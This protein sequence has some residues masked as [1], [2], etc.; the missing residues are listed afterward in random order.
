MKKTKHSLNTWAFLGIYLAIL[1]VFAGVYTLSRRLDQ[2]SQVPIVGTYTPGTYTASDY[3]FGGQVSVSLT[4]GPNGG[5]DDVTL[6]A[7]SETDTIGGAAL[8]ALRNQILSAQSDEIDGVSGATLTSTG[9]RNAV[10]QALAAASGQQVSVAN[11]P[12]EGA[13]FV[14]GT[15]EK[16]AR[17]FG[18]DCTVTLTVSDNEITDVIIDGSSETEN[19]GSFAVTLLQKSIL[20]NQTTKVDAISGATVTSNAILNAA[21]QALNAA[22]AD[23]SKLP[24]AETPEI[25]TA[26]KAQQTVET[27]VVVV[28]A[29]GAGMTAAINAA[30]AGKNV[31]IVEKMP[32]AGGN[33]TKATGGMN[34]AGTKYQA[35]IEFTNAKG[36][37]N[38][39]ATA[40]E[41]WAGNEA[42][43]ALAETVQKQWDAY[44]ADPQGYFDTPELMALDTMIG[45]KGINDSALVETLCSNSAD[46]IDWLDEHGITLHSVSSF[47]GASVKR[48]HRPVNAEGKTVSVGSYMIPLLQENC[49]KAGVQTLLNTTATELLTDANGAVVGV[50]ATGSTGE[51]IT[52]NAKAV[53]LTTG[54]FGANL[55]MVTEYKPELKGFMTTNAAGAQGQGIE[56][57]TAVGA[58]TV[59]MDQIQIHPTVEANTAALIT[60]GLRGDGAVLINAEG[61]RFIDE[62]GTRDVVSAAEI[63]QTGSYSWL[64]VDQA[65][66]DASSVIQGYIKKGYTVTG[67]TY[68]ELA[69]AMGVDEAAF[70][71]T[72]KTWNGYV[73]AKNDPD[74]GR[75]SFA[76]ALDTAPYYAIKVTAGVHHTMGGL[77]IN[78]NTEVLKADGSVIPGLF[79]AGE[80]TGGVHGAN[81]LGGNAVAD[82]TVFGRIAG[83]AASKYAA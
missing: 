10:T 31:L 54:G 57:A 5:I 4:V 81:R 7:P 1:A 8:P 49:D 52:V 60:E 67:Q 61:K 33:S 50:K 70:A 39:L 43:T 18:G 72:M 53:V 83:A 3:G 26:D 78:T 2:A 38:T 14:P 35:Q 6:D 68:E 16:S 69:K 22:G 51:T 24:A 19:I 73:A 74:F 37:E 9:V 71:E 25:A 27:D 17:G 15:Y 64:V 65:M 28:G 76:K 23:L 40:K 29:G 55:D 20:E 66:V 75:T 63:A 62:V 56:M 12:A 46:A 34:A 30:H 59:D 32:Y 79:A 44:Q 47:G 82:F 42:I 58:D 13:L 21:N 45:G 48:I 80:V 36:V 41:K 11:A 77:K